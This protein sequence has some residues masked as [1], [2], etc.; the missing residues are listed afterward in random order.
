VHEAGH[1]PKR[2]QR[3]SSD[4]VH[5]GPSRLSPGYSLAIEQADGPVS[6]R[7]NGCTVAVLA[8]SAFGPAPES[9]HLAVEEDRRVLDG[10]EEDDGGGG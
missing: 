3:V 4:P 9:I 1:G 8:L 5:E 7:P 6:G 10:A 2:G